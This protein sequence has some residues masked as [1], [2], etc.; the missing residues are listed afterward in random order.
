M[1]V[2]TERDRILNMI[3]DD[4]KEIKSKLTDHTAKIEGLSARLQNGLLKK[5]DTLDKR[6]WG[7]LVGLLGV[8]VTT[9]INLLLM[10]I[11]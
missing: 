2:A 5:V 11:G 4:M 8:L 3:T 10:V 9:V 1:S 6:M 7:L